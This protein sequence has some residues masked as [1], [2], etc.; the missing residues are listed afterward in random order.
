MKFLSFILLL[1]TL[2]APAQGE[3][4]GNADSWLDRIDAIE[5]KYMNQEA[6]GLSYEEKQRRS[7]PAPKDG[8]IQ[9]A[10]VQVTGVS[11]TEKALESIAGLVAKLDASVAQIEEDIN[12]TRRNIIEKSGVSNY[13]EIN[14]VIPKSERSVLQSIDVRVD[15][16]KIAEYGDAA[17]LWLPDGLLPIFAGPL[18]AGSHRIDI[19]ARVVL[20]STDGVALPVGAFRDANYSSEIVIGEGLKSAK[21]NYM[22]EQPSAD[23]DKLAIKLQES[24]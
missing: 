20:R 18:K 13:I 4:L 3:P 9:F 22:I 10:P 7:T 14:A 21:Y 24:I 5:K 12:K 11:D 2:V 19:K 6:E 16:Y 15:G 23:S 17:G 1:I 8:A